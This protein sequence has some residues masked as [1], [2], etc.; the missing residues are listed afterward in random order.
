MCA[1]LTN[2]ANAASPEGGGADTLQ[3]LARLLRVD[4]DTFAEHVAPMVE[5]NVAA[6]NADHPPL[7]RE[8]LGRME[9]ETARLR[10]ETLLAALDALKAC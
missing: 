4:P 2:D 6:V 9:D 7:L 5:R 10:M 3:R 8:A 1:A